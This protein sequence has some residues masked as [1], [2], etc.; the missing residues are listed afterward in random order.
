M[1][2]EIRH[3]SPREAR[4]KQP[5]SRG[6]LE[7]KQELAAILRRLLEATRA[8]RTTLRIDDARHGIHS[9]EVLAE[10]LAPGQASMAGDKSIRHRAA[11]TAQWLEAN[12]RLLVQNDFT[13]GGPEAPQALREVFGVMGQ[14]L[15]PVVRDGRLDGWVSVHLAGTTRV[16][17]PSDQAA[18]ERAASDVIAAL[19]RM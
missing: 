2:L 11:A 18:A 13:S 10:V 14:M 9:D 4:L 5:V 3:L 7:V 16:W 12:G 6:M 17:S 15:A 1:S 19:A 8:S